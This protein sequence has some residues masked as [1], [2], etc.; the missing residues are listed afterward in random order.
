MSSNI[1][2]KTEYNLEHFWLW[3]NTLRLSIIEEEE[4][5]QE[6]SQLK[7]IQSLKESLSSTPEFE[8]IADRRALN[9]KLGEN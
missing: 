3:I 2:D 5:M 7:E 1:K 4:E 6:E 8:M 9:L